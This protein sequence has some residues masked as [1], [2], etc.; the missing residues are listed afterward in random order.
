MKRQYSATYD[1]EELRRYMLSQPDERLLEIVTLERAQYIQPALN[2]AEAELRLRG[3]SFTVPAPVPTK[4]AV[5]QSSNGKLFA[6]LYGL[7]CLSLFLAIVLG[8]YADWLFSVYEWLIK[9]VIGASAALAAV[10]ALF[11]L[12]ERLLTW[13]RPPRP[14][15]H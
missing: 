1:P 2:L 8:S 10:C 15:K 6:R 4:T 7:V 14:L 12:A 5:A 9:V 3:V 13:L 11:W